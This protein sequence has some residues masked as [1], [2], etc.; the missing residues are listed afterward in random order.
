MINHPKIINN[1]L[2]LRQYCSSSKSDIIKGLNY[3]NKELFGA[4]IKSK[5]KPTKNSQNLNDKI[6]VANTVSQDQHSW[7]SE[8]YWL[9]RH[10]TKATSHQPNTKLNKTSVIK[11]KPK[12]ETFV[13][14]TKPIEPIQL[15]TPI[16]LQKHKFSPDSIH[17]TSQFDINPAKQIKITSTLRKFKQSLL[18]TPINSNAKVSYT[19]EYIEV[20]FSENDIKNML[21]YPMICDETNIISMD[22]NSNTIEVSKMPSVSKILQATMP[23]ASRKALMKWKLLKIAELGEDGFNELQKCIIFYLYRKY[24]KTC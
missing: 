18:R 12:L 5:K 6:A 2:T 20:P 11:S 14:V 17:I 23:E 8:M 22:D 16:P 24:C 7:N 9:M 3:T 1:L 13:P 15:S 4:V 19:N 10:D 21:K